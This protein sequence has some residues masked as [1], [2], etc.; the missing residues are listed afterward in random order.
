MFGRHP[1]LVGDIVLDINKDVVYK[2]DYI[3]EV[4]R[5]LQTAYLK[6]KEAILKSNNKHKGCY[7]KNL[8]IIR[9]LELGD[10]VVTRKLLR[11]LK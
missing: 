7:D 2:N 6:C 10:V 3:R 11:S 8:P 1:R 9:Q 5:Y 4:R